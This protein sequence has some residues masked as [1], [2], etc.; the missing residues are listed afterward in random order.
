[1]E[2]NSDAYQL[3]GVSKSYAGREVLNVSRLDIHRAETLAIVGPNGAGKSTLL[4]I[5]GFLEPCSEGEIRYGGKAIAYPPPLELR[6]R[7]AHVFQRPLMLKRS[8]WS[9]V[10]YGLRLRGERNDRAV[11]EMLARLDLED[12]AHEPAVS[13]S[14]GEMQRV[15]LARALVLEPDVLLLDEPTANLDPSNVGLLEAMIESIHALGRTTIVLV[16]HNV[17]QARRRADRVAMLLGGKLIEVAETSAFFDHPA[18]SRVSAFVRG[19][20]VY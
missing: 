8:V 16:T 20:M 14:G 3:R 9:N 5:L 1:M 17:F 4:R 18:D 6:R 10:A 2:M 12:L 11:D 19:E 15:A 7:I 13:L